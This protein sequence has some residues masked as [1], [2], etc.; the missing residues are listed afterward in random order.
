[1][2]ECRSSW[3]SPGRL[4]VSTGQEAEYEYVPD[5]ESGLLVWVDKP[6]VVAIGPDLEL[7][8]IV[9]TLK[10]DSV[11]KVTDSTVGVFPTGQHVLTR[12]S[13]TRHTRRQW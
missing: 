12:S 1:V 3:S 13:W 9:G 2:N 7:T 4:I 6:H 8:G 11:G 10:S 5:V